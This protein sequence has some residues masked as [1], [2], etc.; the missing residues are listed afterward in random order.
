MAE[1]VSGSVPAFAE[2]M[3]KTAAD[4][5]CKNTHFTNPNGLHDNNHY[6][7]AYDMAQIAGWHI[8]MK[9]SGRC[10]RNRYMSLRKQ[11]KKKNR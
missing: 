2:L 9:N 6:T 4:I 1:A 3:N 5:G 11:I 8:Q 10:F 7:T